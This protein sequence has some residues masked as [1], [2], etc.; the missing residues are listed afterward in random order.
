MRK[1]SFTLLELIVVVIIITILGT[2]GFSQY[3]IVIEKSRTAEAKA[4]LAM[5]R[6]LQL[7]YY[8]RYGE[9][10]NHINLFG[11]ALPDGCND[12]DPPA[13][14]FYYYYLCCPSNFDC[15]INSGTGASISA[16]TCWATRG[17]TGCTSKRPLVSYV[18]NIYLDIKGDYTGTAGYY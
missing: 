6:R 2:L 15:G 18:I 13:S 16:G 14:K 3:V 4:N 12:D 8:A 17:Y 7:A 9:Y 11:N 5:L 10:A 1:K